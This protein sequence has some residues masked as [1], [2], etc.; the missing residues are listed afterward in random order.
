M[1]E[2][3]DVFPEDLPRIPPEHEIDFGVDLDPNTKPISTPQYRMDLAELKEF[4]C[5]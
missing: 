2:F 4:H 3:Q 5:S 1:N